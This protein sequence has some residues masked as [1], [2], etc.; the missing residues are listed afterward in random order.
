MERLGGRKRVK[1]E[2]GNTLFRALF[3]RMIS[4]KGGAAIRQD[5]FILGSWEIKPGLA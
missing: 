2:T 5:V 3:H 4:G 1:G